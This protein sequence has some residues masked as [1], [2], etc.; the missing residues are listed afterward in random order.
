MR[1]IYDDNSID[2]EIWVQIENSYYY[3][4]NYGRIKSTYQNTEKI[5]KC[6]V[7]K[8]GYPVFHMRINGKSYLKTIHRFVAKYFVANPKNKPQV[9]HID[10]NKQNNYYRNLEWV[11]SKENILHAREHGLRTSDGQKKTAQYDL[12]GNLIKIFNSSVEASKITGIS[13]GSI[14]SVCRQ[15]PKYKTAGGYIWRYV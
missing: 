8:R 9:N 3:V 15:I 4:S 5:L 6:S 14:C 10:G 2:A 7:S 1:E 11:T 12:N 13:R